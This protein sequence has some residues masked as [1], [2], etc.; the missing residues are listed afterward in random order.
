[1]EF[2]FHKG[3]PRAL[4]IHNGIKEVTVKAGEDLKINIPFEGSPKPK[5]A[6][7]KV[8]SILIREKLVLIK[9]L[10]GW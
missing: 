3:A 9:F 6:W 4:G 1:M 2:F 8:S 5:V 7:T 10:I